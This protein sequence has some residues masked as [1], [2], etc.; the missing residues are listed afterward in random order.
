M[1]FQDRVGD[2][3]GVVSEIA[4]GTVQMVADGIGGACGGPRGLSHATALNARKVMKEGQ[5][6]GEGSKVVRK[7]VPRG[8]GEAENRMQAAGN[9]VGEPMLWS[10]NEGTEAGMD[11]IQ[12]RR[13]K[14]VELC[15]V[16]EEG[17]EKG[18]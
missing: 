8:D 3:D 2:G 15:I 5:A 13:R 11:G 10:A 6:P 1:V 12:G 7:H 18:K 14:N 16:A 4:G 17:V 9:E